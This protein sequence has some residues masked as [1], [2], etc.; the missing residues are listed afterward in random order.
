MAAGVVVVA[1]MTIPVSSNSCADV[2]AGAGVWVQVGFPVFC[3]SDPIAVGSS[4][5]WSNGTVYTVTAVTATPR[6][7][8]LPFKAQP[9]DYAA[10][11]IIFGLILAAACLVWGGKQVLNLLRDRPEN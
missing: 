10:V 9:E 11:S 6:N 2:M 8:M 1:G 3:S 5:D 4:F 7:E